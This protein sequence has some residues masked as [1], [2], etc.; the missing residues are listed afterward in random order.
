MKGFSVIDM[1][2]M[3]VLPQWNSWGIFAC[4]TFIQTNIYWESRMGPGTA[5]RP[6][7]VKAD[8][9]WPRRALGTEEA[10]M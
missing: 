6:R 10:E 5:L 4:V 9:H 3:T 8:G 1:E 7:D 2:M